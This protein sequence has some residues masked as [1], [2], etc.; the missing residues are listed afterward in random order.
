MEHIVH[1][2]NFIMQDKVMRNLY[3]IKLV[4]EIKEISKCINLISVTDSNLQR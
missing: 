2:G 4:L 3:D 1:A